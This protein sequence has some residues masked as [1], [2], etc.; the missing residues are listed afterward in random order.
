MTPLR[1]RPPFRFGRLTFTNRDKPRCSSPLLKINC[2]LLSA[3]PR[4]LELIVKLNYSVL[5]LVK[6]LPISPL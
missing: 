3:K 6:M 2:Y 5:T 1:S 4:C